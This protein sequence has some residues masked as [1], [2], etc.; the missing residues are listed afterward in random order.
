MSNYW[1]WWAGAL[2][3]AVVTIN[4]TVTTDRSFGVSSAWERVLQWRAERRVERMEA[5]FTDDRQLAEAL[6]SATAEHF[7]PRAG[8]PT[9]P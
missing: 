3:L 2:G 6:A 5:Q 1:P 8:A 7:G 4:Y 9:A